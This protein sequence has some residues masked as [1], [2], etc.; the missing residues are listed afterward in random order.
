M[1]I[2][3]IITKKIESQKQEEIPAFVLVYI[4]NRNFIVSIRLTTGFKPLYTKI[5]TV[6]MNLIVIAAI[7]L[8]NLY[9]TVCIIY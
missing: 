4:Y 2:V 3:I 9:I 5:A 1:K 7:V 8:L 6:T